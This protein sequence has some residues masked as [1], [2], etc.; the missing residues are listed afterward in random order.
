VTTRFGLRYQQPRRWLVP[1]VEVTVPTVVS[2]DPWRLHHEVVH[3]AYGLTSGHAMVR[4]QRWSRAH[5][6]P[7]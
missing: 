3:T 2:M 4:A 6:D 5:G 1:A 7:R